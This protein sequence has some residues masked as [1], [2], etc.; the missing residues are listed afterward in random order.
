MCIVFVD[1]LES[2]D[3]KGVLFKMIG[4]VVLFDGMKVILCF[5][6]NWQVMVDVVSWKYMEWGY[7]NN[8][9]NIKDKQF[10]NVIML[11]ELWKKQF[12]IQEVFYNVLIKMVVNL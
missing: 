10:D 4:L 1:K 2:V 7:F 3:G 6:N 12:V 8:M 5:V 9:F 11:M